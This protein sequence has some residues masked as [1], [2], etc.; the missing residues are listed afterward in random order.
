MI[1][2]YDINFIRCATIT[3]R[4]REVCGAWWQFHCCLRDRLSENKM[5]S[6]AVCDANLDISA[7]LLR[8]CPSP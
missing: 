6:S 1:R 7:P 2:L 3:L 4:L 8:D 5:Y